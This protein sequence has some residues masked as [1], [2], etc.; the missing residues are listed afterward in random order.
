MSL[1]H[2]QNLGRVTPLAEI[3]SD[4]TAEKPEVEKPIKK[5]PLMLAVEQ[6]FAQ[7]GESI[8]DLLKR[9]YVDEDKG[10]RVIARELSR[11]DD[12]KVNHNSI[13][14]WVTTLHPEIP[15][16]PGIDQI[17]KFRQDP[18][19]EQKRIAG[20]REYW[21]TRPAEKA[22][23]IRRMVEA[24]LKHHEANR[25]AAL[26]NNPK[27]TLAQ[28]V[29][30]EGL[31]RGEIAKKVGK[32]TTTISKWLKEYGIITKRVYGR[33][34]RVDAREIENRR[35]KIQRAKDAGLFKLLTPREQEVLNALYTNPGKPPT[36]AKVARDLEVT[37][38]NIRQ[39]DKRGLA[40]IDKLLEYGSTALKKKTRVDQLLGDDP[41]QL[42]KT[43][44]DQSLFIKDIAT[45]LGCSTFSIAKRMK[46]LGIKRR[47]KTQV[48]QTNTRPPLSDYNVDLA[49]AR[50]PWPR[51]FAVLDI[52]QRV[53]NRLCIAGYTTIRDVYEA[54][55]AELLSLWHFGNKSLKE[56]RGELGKFRQE[57]V[58][59]NETQTPDSTDQTFPK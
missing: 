16:R 52:S 34:Q 39:F 57:V 9:M 8:A 56:L 49:L 28:R 13:R 2:S 12:L 35:K 23:R 33:R 45:K 7:P 17:K 44:T 25:F 38:E 3:S 22:Q 19:F 59:N 47:K 36:Q 24:N 46:A 42:L 50:R 51:E 10:F 53:Y 18:K 43:Y 4:P 41:A 37:R 30:V 20:I 1:E 21:K 31:S 26:G 58:E 27:E 15:L 55:D 29:Y 54:P 48:L 14:S 40:K 32:T 11:H 6:K 5:T